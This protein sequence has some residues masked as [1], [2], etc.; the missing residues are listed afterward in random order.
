[1]PS[2]T[3]NGP[4]HQFIDQRLELRAGQFH[5]KVLR[6]GLIRRYERQV[7]IRFHCAGQLDLGFFAGFLEALQR[8]LSSRRSIPFSFLNSSAK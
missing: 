8:S 2:C 1:M 3:F 4:L 7:N 5:I 6:S